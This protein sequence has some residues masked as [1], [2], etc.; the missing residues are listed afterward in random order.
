MLW[1]FRILGGICLIFLGILIFKEYQK[2]KQRLEL[3]EELHEIE[4]SLKCSDLQDQINE[5]TNEVIQQVEK[6]YKKYVQ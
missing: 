3:S 1:A 2:Y 6:R 5:K 4:E